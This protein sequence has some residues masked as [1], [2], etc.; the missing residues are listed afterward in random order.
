MFSE[1]DM[2]T[3]QSIYGHNSLKAQRGVATLSTALILLL[4]ITLMTFSAA[5]VSVVEQKIAANDY[6][7]KQALHAA[8]GAIEVAVYN[9]NVITPALNTTYTGVLPVSTATTAPCTAAG[10]C[11]SYVY[12]SVLGG[13]PA[14]TTLLRVTATGYSDDGSASKSVVQYVKLYSPLPRIPTSPVKGGGEYESESNSISIVNNITSTAI[15]T[16]DE[17]DTH[18]KNVTSV[19]GVAGAGLV[20]N[21]TTTGV[22]G[23]VNTTAERDAFFNSVFGTSKADIQS[24]SLPATCSGNCNTQLG[25]TGTTLSGSTITNYGTPQSSLLWV[26]GNTTLNSNTVIGSPTKPVVLVI[27]GT[28]DIQGGATVYGFIYVTGNVLDN[29]EGVAA[30]LSGNTNVVGGI[31]AEEDLKFK[32]T[33]NVTYNQFT[34]GGGPAGPDFYVKVPGTWI[35]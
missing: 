31:A 23:V 30:E 15:E 26:T 8:E 32:G 13:S 24:L 34:N 7:A 14:S 35:D 19:N 20:P 12:T 4:A 33:V 25:N 21:A 18:H 22:T 9:S 11:Y 3:E 2:S 10:I 6:R 16:Q 17:I 28:L 1:V 29:K 5:R 27:N